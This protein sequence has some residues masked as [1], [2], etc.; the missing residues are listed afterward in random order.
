MKTL[1]LLRHA[2]SDWGDPDL[3][4]EQRPL[5]DR[6]K[7]DAKRLA[8]YLEKHPI[9]VDMVFCSPAKRAKQTLKAIERALRAPV[10]EEQG[11]YGAGEE[12][13]LKFVR[14]LPGKLDAVLLIGH[15]PGFEELARTLLPA[16]ASPPAFPTCALAS[17]TFDASGWKSVGPG[18]ASLAGF[19]TPAELKS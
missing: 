9:A 12:Q 13:L 17:L 18:K 16:T 4:D 15:N 19:L 8:E 5:N 14:R 11:L 6:G 7:R 2:K 3:S 1:H 10:T